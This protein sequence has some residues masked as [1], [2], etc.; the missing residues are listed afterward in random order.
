[1]RKKVF[2]LLLFITLGY[3]LYACKCNG[4]EELMTAYDDFLN[5]KLLNKQTNQ[6]LLGLYGIYK[7]DTVKIYNEQGQKVFNG[8]VELN[9]QINL[10]NIIERQ[11]SRAFSDTVRKQYYLYLNQHDTDTISVD[12]MLQKSSPC[13]IDE[14][15]FVQVY[16]NDSL[17]INRNSIASIDFLK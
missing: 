4:G 7:A 6:S 8:P 13:K 9:G 1:M 2:Y 15:R 11:D 3:G 5:F 14:I 17:Y 16:F 10:F 12:F